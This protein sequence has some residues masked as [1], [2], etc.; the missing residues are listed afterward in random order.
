MHYIFGDIHGCASSLAG[1]YG[2]LK[3]TLRREDILVFLGDYI[4]RGKDSC[5]VI[6][7]LLDLAEKHPAI[8]LKGNHESMLLNYLAGRDHQ[9]LYFYNGGEYTLESYRR[10]YGVASIPDRHMEFFRALKLYYETD[11]FIAVHAGLNPTIETVRR[12]DE[13]ELLWIRERF[14]FADRQWEKTVVFG[15]TPVACLTGNMRQVYRDEWRNIIG[16]DTGAVYGG[17]LTCLRMP[18]GRIFQY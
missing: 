5:E 13:E 14:Y 16:I 4:D 10:E 8:F 18:D 9:G 15:H 17:V 11:N 7:F 1:L 12:Q 3:R 2:K 6:Q